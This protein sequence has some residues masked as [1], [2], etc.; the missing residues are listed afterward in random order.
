MLGKQGWVSTAS[1]NPGGTVP[2]EVPSIY[3]PGPLGSSGKVVSIGLLTPR[4]AKSKQS[5]TYRA[6]IGENI[7]SGCRWGVPGGPTPG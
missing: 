7:Q 2:L 6:R 3:T 1:P 5:G 4:L